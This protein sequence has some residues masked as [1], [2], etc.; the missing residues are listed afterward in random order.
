MAKEVQQITEEEK[1]HEQWFEEAK[2]VTPETLPAFLE[3]V[4]GDYGHDYGTACHALTACA[5][6]AAWAAN[7]HPGSRGGIT[8]FQAG[9][10]M[11]GFVQHWQNIKGPVRL[12][13]YEKMLYPQY[14]EKFQKT[15][16]PDTWKWLCEQAAE[17]LK[18]QE[19]VHPDVVMHWGRIMAGEVPFGYT[20]LGG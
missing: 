10:V 13:E 16:T 6:A 14:E 3:H 1:I 15:I 8:G 12:V 7:H 4:M 20:V 17:K 2:N 5:L 11:W 9:C 19:N 18:D